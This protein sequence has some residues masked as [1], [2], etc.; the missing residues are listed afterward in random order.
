M[1]DHVAAPR[2]VTFPGW[3]GTSVWCIIRDNAVTVIRLR[4][5]PIGP[6][7]KLVDVRREG[8]AEWCGSSAAEIEA[9]RL[10]GGAQPVTDG[11][12][13]T[14]LLGIEANS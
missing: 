10:N 4:R 13:Q 12:M 2:F 5:A 9:F 14:M 7:Y 8:N 1:T 3:I 6:G 11:D